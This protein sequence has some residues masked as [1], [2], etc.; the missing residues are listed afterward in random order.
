MG[1]NYT[2]NEMFSNVW[3]CMYA[4]FG[5]V[6]MKDC[7]ISTERSDIHFSIART[8]VHDYDNSFGI[9]DSVYFTDRLIDPKYCDFGVIVEEPLPGW[10]YVNVT[11][12]DGKVVKRRTRAERVA[13]K[14][15]DFV[16]TWAIHINYLSGCH[17]ELFADEK[18]NKYVP[19]FFNDQLVIY[20]RSI[21]E[22][23]EAIAHIK[24]FCNR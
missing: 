13:R 2:A 11:N 7:V 9:G 6:T 3:P 22:M 18:W 5:D 24:Q 17:D 15:K 19:E 16:A 1:L 23:N 20:P 8:K 4:N 21:E 12:S 10:F 14:M